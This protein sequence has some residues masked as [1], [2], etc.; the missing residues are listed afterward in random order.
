MECI[1]RIVVGLDLSP[2]CPDVWREACAL[3]RAFD[4][5]LHLVYAVE[6]ALAGT[7][8]LEVAREGVSARLEDLRRAA[9]QEQV[10][11]AEVVSIR[12]GSPAEAILAVSREVEA[13]VVVIG[14]GV[15][16][17]RDSVIFGSTAERVVR[18]AEAPVWV[19]RPGKGHARF[20]RVVVALDPRAPQADSLK[21][22]AL[23]AMGLDARLTVVAVTPELDGHDLIEARIRSALR[24]AA[25]EGLVAGVEVRSAPKP[26]AELVGVVQRD[27]VSLLVMGESD[28]AG[29][30]FD[31]STVEKVLRLVPCSILRVKPAREAALTTA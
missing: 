30:P 22:G 3:A 12:P 6:D 9:A 27:D 26:S 15:R 5:E 20:E 17:G 13:D 28:R 21:A 25:A 4:A 16:A 8:Q 29:G 11:V 23:L 1:Q 18:E 31:R 19:V 10:Q 2:E 7:P 24:T 14:A